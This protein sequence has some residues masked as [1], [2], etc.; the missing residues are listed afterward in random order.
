MKI[1]FTKTA[2]KEYLSYLHKDR[3]TFRKIN[4]LIEDIQT[5]GIFNGIGKPEKLRYFNPP[6]YSRRI[7]KGDRLIYSLYGKNNDELMIYSCRGHYEDK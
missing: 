7:T 4:E 3:Q 6:K 5:N 2:E 1:N